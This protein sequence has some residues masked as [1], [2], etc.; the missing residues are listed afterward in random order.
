MYFGAGEV[1]KEN[2]KSNVTITFIMISLF[3]YMTKLPN[4]DLNFN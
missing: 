2:Q 1:R 4:K 3:Y